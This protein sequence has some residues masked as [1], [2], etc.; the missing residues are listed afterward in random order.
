MPQITEPKPGEDMR[1]L[2][3]IVRDLVKAVNA[4]Q[5]MVVRVT[6]DRPTGGKLD[7]QGDHCTININ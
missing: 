1:D 3:L 6:T 2:Y 5:N 7:M 4:L